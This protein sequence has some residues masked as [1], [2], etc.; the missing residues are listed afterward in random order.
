[1]IFDLHTHTTLSPCSILNIDT[2]IDSAAK[3]GLN[4]VCITD[5]QTMAIR[6]I[7][8]EGP[9]DNG[10]V[11]IFGMEYATLDGDFLLFGPYEKLPKDLDAV[12]LLHHVNESNGAAIAAHPFRK[13]RPVSEPIIENGHCAIV[14]G[15]NGRNSAIENLRIEAWRQRY[16]LTETGGSDAHSPEELGK[17]VTRFSQPIL[18]RQD[19][20]SALHHGDYRP[21]WYETSYDLQPE[22]Q[23]IS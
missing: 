12:D 21:E 18:S 2:I 23:S 14:E 11:L 22:I 4:G 9:Q 15:I 1:M 10:V 8:K 13:K 7:V 5:H 16:R 6:H 3:I 17:V 20:I 19:F